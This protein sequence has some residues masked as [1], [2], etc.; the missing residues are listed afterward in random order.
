MHDL[1]RSA[2][3]AAVSGV[4][5][6]RA[7]ED[8]REELSRSVY[9]EAQP[10]LAERALE[11]LLARVQEALDTAG[12]LSPGGLTGLVGALLLVVALVLLVRWRTGPLARSAVVHGASRG[13]LTAADHRALAD[14]AAAEQRWADSVR[15][16]MRALVRELELRGVLEP[17]AGRTASE[18]ARE[19]GAA[20]PGLADGLR[21][22]AEV[23]DEIWY[24][25]RPATREAAEEIRAVDE[26][27]RSARLSVPSATTAPSPAVLP[28]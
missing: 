27:V 18:V 21:R 22:A 25:G 11:W 19:A 12:S 16:R 1:P 6:D 28:R 4:D 13:V 10:G 14:S 7:R 2:A 9:A 5:R 3:I 26:A 20:V 23:F 8:A 24:G 17:R 15:E